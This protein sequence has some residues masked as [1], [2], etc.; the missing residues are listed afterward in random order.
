[1]KGGV[2]DECGI[3]VSKRDKDGLLVDWLGLVPEWHLVGSMEN[4]FIEHV[5]VAVVPDRCVD[6]SCSI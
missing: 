5:E 6:Q 2:P 3:V 1:M 4:V